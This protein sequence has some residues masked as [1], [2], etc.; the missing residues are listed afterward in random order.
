MG[1]PTDSLIECFYHDTP[2]S[3]GSGVFSVRLVWSESKESHMTDVNVEETWGKGEPE[4]EDTVQSEG[5]Q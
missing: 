4:P 3:F 1:S 2:V 5:R